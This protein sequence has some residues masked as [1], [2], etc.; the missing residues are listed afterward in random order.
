MKP[1]RWIGWISYGLYLWHWPIYVWLTPERAGASG[2]PLLA[3]RLSVTFAVATASYY[4][5]EQPI[6]R[7]VLKPRRALVVAPA[8]AMAVAV[9]LV[10]VTSSTVLPGRFSAPASASSSAAFDEEANA[11]RLAEQQRLAAQEG[12]QTALIVGDS[13]ANVLAFFY[14][15]ELGSPGVALPYEVELGCG[16]ARGRVF[17]QGRWRPSLPQCENWPERWQQ[18]VEVNDPD[19]SIMLVGIWELFDREV[20]GRH[21]RFGTPEWDAYLR[22]ELDTALSILTAEGRTALVLS[23]PCYEYRPEQVLTWGPERGDQQRIAHVNELFAE[24]VARSPGDARLVDLNGFLCE[25][26]AYRDVDLGGAPLT[27]DGVHLTEAGAHYV[28]RWLA[29]QVKDAAVQAVLAEEPV[30]T[31]LS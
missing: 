9:V 29:P 15:E 22:G 2:T 30:D 28:W 8:T 6:R 11:Q 20:D 26:G 10:L 21:L 31:K 13:V 16:I 1:L 14:L 18:A 4:F 25:D 17:T 7:G 12:T 19:V 24:A 5:V 23:V 3:L 27:D